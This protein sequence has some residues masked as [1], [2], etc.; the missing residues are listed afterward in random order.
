MN[1]QQKNLLN[2]IRKINLSIQLFEELED[3]N[4]P[5]V[6]FI[7]SYTL[8]YIVSRLTPDKR[9][10][11]VNLLKQDASDDKIWQFVNKYIENFSDNYAKE[12]EKKLRRIKNKVLGSKKGK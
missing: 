10:E 4:S 12:L 11:F 8:N 7:N 1:K 3:D 9:Q 2:F 5:L 6:N